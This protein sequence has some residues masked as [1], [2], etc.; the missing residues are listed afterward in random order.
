MQ[1]QTD[2]LGQALTAARPNGIT[3]AVVKD[4]KGKHN[5]ITLGLGRKR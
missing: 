4:L 1:R 3:I 2:S 5:P